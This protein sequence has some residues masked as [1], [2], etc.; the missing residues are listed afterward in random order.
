MELLAPV[1][2][3]LGGLAV[4]LRTKSLDDADSDRPGLTAVMDVVSALGR[5]LHQPDTGELRTVLPALAVLRE[6]LENEGEIDQTPWGALAYD[7][8]EPFAAGSLWALSTVI[9]EILEAE[10]TQARQLEA[11][12]TRAEV[13]NAIL[14]L[15]SSEAALTGTDVVFELEERGQSVAR[16]TV[17]KAIGDLLDEGRLHPVSAPADSDRRCRW[18]AASPAP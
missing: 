4:R 17:S 2:D 14:Q 12:A 9:H 15:A 18:Y 3:V 16:P 1:I 13:R 10:A 5:S 11:R 6:T 7:K 8:S